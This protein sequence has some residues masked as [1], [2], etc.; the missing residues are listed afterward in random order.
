MQVAGRA[1]RAHKQGLV[2]LQTSEPGHPVIEFV[3]AHDY[4]GFFKHELQERRQFAFPPFVR[5][6]NIYL[7]HRDEATVGEMAVRFSQLLRHTFGNRILGPEAPPVG[8]VQQLFIRQIVLKVEMQASMPKVK[9]VLRGLYEQM[10]TLDGRMK[11]IRLHYD[12]DPV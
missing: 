5:I 8:R 1:G 2:I 4:E 6:I 10:L 7:R 3:K 11:G 12:V 9:K